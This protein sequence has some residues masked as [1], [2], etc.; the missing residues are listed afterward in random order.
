[1]SGAFFKFFL[2]FC[3]GKNAYNGNSVNLNLAT[4]KITKTYLRCM[5]IAS[6]EYRLNEFWNSIHMYKIQT[7]FFK[8]MLSK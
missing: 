4:D 8:K 5:N 6:I 2:K 7:I 1:M 3:I